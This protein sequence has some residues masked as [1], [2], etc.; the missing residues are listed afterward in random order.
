MTR[1]LAE[2]VDAYNAAHVVLCDAG[3][4][5]GFGPR[6]VAV[7]YDAGT[8]ADLAMHEIPKA[9]GRVSEDGFVMTWQSEWQHDEN[10]YR[11]RI[12]F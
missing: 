10:G 2:I 5:A 11:W 1:T 8:M 9:E 12:R 6:G 3:N 7:D 4:G